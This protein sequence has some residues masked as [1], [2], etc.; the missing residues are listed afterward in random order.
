MVSAESYDFIIVGAG[1]AGCVLA[2]RLTAS[3]D[4]SVLLIEA[5][6]RDSSPWIHIPLGYGKHFTNPAV[7]WL[8][9]NEPDDAVA[10]RRVPTPRGKV[11]GG[12]SSINGLVYIRGQAADYDMWRQLGNPGWAYDDVLPY[13]RKSEDQQRGADEWHGAGGPLAVSDRKT[14]HELCDAFLESAAKCGYPRTDDFNRADNEGFGY[15]QLTTRNGRRCSAAVAFLRPAEKRRNLTVVTH[16][17]ATRILFE[18][19]RATGIEYSRRGRL[20]T[21]RA[22]R[23]V[24][25]SG[26]AVNT[27]QLL[28]LSGIGSA[29]RLRTYGIDIVADRPGVGEN[30][31]DHFSVRL[32]WRCTKPLTLNDALAN[33][34]RGARELAKYAVSR[35]GFLAMGASVAAGF[36]KSDTAQATPDIQVGLNLFSGDRLGEKLHPFSG[37]CA[38]V[39]LLRPESRGT[40]HIRSADPLAAPEIRS[41]FLHREKDGTT[42]A[43]AC[44]MF[45]E[46]AAA[47]PLADYIESEY[48]PGPAVADEAAMLDYMRKTGATSFHPVGTCRM[49]SDPDA[50]V[51]PR[52]RVNGVAALRVADASIMPVIVSGNTNA[53]AI[54]IGEKA[55]DMILEDAG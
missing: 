54:M 5:G 1:S 51:D 4:H 10:G 53:P 44:M 47:R 27:P 16:A 13:F 24:I 40:I 14:P 52:L 25:L 28:E 17:H 49:G 15:L 3:G 34:L 41:N 50:V 38:A 43:R 19:Q 8:Y 37:F 11:L 22:E 20:A 31:Q 46:I 33:P 48:L 23:E 18:G 30:L 26:G 2:N 7:N 21:A 35:D 32:T 29:D 12:S 45:R 55:S 42:L 9:S 39:R 6:G 36:Y